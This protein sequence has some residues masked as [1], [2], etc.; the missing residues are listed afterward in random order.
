MAA[1]DSG[2]LGIAACA[3]GLAQAALDAAV[4]YARER[5]QFGQAIIDHQGVGFMLADMAAA[6]SRPRAP[7]WP[8]PGC[9]TPGCPFARRRRSRSCRTDAAMK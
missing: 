1:L 8:R 2:R 5:E 9:A 4:A 7:T 3:V 6:S